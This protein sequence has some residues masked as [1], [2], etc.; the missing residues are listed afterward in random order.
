[1]QITDLFPIVPSAKSCTIKMINWQMVPALLERNTNN[2]PFSETTC[3][4]Y[5]DIIYRKAWGFDGVPIIFDVKGRLVDGQHRLTALLLEKSSA[6]FVVVFGADE[7]AFA[8]IGVTRPR[9]LSQALGILGFQNANALLG[10]INVCMHPEGGKSIGLA[11]DQ[12][13]QFMQENPDLVD[14]LKFISAQRGHSNLGP[15]ALFGALH[16]KFSQIDRA[17]ADN[18]W[19]YVLTEEGKRTPATKLL[20]TRLLESGFATNPSKQLKRNHIWAL[21]VKAWNAG[22]ENIGLLG[23]RPTQESFPQ[24]TIPHC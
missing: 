24:I 6:T 5:R 20:R 12:M 19:S 9:S 1:M 7:D 18:F 14:S 11:A 16:Y 23:F 21:V 15:L 17:L 2:R 3:A 8:K 4:K 10:A 22:T 13:E